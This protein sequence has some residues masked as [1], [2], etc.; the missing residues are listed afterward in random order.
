MKSSVCI[1]HPELFPINQINVL[2]DSIKSSTKMMGLM[3]N[4]IWIFLP[5]KYKTYR[6]L[7]PIAG[8]KP[9]KELSKNEQDWD[10]RARQIISRELGHS[11][12]SVTKIYC[13]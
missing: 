5:N 9:F 10:I 7:P 4:K 13:G 11:R 6:L 2:R 1:E 3:P 8:G 12:L